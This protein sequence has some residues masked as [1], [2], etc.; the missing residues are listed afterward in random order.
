MSHLNGFSDYWASLR[1]DLSGQ[2]RKAARTC[3]FRVLPF[4]CRPPELAELALDGYLGR[5]A[6]CLLASPVLP[7][8][9]ITTPGSTARVLV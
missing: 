5:T 2:A 8:R 9:H 1:E 6:C 3:G 4:P 7:F